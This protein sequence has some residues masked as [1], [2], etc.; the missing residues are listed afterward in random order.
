MNVFKFSIWLLISQN[1]LLSAY[2]RFVLYSGNGSEFNSRH[3]TPIMYL[4]QE[5]GFVEM[6]RLTVNFGRPLMELLADCRD[7]PY[8]NCDAGHIMPMCNRAVYKN[9][10][11]RKCRKTCG[12]CKGDD[13]PNPNPIPPKESC[14]DDK[15]TD[16]Q[17]PGNLWGLHYNDGYKPSNLSDDTNYRDNHNYGYKPANLSDDADYRDNRLFADHYNNFNAF[18]SHDPDDAVN[19]D[20][21]YNTDDSNYTDYRDNRLFADHYNNFNAF[22]AKLRVYCDFSDLSYNSDDSHNANYAYDSNHI[23]YSDHPNDHR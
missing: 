6:K 8:S 10:M 20:Y 14:A 23:D 1:L 3:T 22:S 11:R 21:A 19:A 4:P 16:C 9:I 5:D 17:K 13:T 2:A 7:D 18:D 12:F 15:T